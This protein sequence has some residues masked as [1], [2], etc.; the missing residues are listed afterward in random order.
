[1]CDENRKQLKDYLED[2]GTYAWGILTNAKQLEIYAYSSEENDFVL[3]EKLSG[4]INEEQFRYICEVISNKEKLVITDL[5]INGYL[6]VDS[7]KEIIFFSNE[8]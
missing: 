5:N 2:L 7:N 3:N 8:G 1:M 4:E 6:G